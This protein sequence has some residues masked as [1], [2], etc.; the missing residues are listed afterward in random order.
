MKEESINITLPLPI[1]VNWAYSWNRKRRKSNVYI[2]WLEK[3]EIA[4]SQY[5]FD[6]TISGDEWL[7]VEYKFF[8]PIY[9]KNGTKKK[10]DAMNYEKVLSDFL[11]KS[12]DGFEDKKILKAKIEK[13]DSNR[14][15]VEVVIKEIQ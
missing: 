6:Y 15:E 8:F 14:N 12:I 2:E 5:D 7:E 4:Y 11:E 13:I 10:K 3:A 1:S 9:N